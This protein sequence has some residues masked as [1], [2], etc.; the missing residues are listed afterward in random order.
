MTAKALMA[1]VFGARGTGKNAWLKQQLRVRPPRLVVWDHKHDPTMVDVGQGV[2]DLGELIR[3]MKGKRFALRYLPDH[4]GDIDAQF[5]LF[6]RACFLV[7]NLC[8][9]VDELPEVTKANRAPAAWRQ[10]V[11]VG[12]L[13]RGA[14]GVER[15]LVIFGLGQRP[16]ECDKSF[17][18]NLD[19]LHTGRVAQASDARALA[20]LLNVDYRELMRL[21]DLHWVERRQGQAEP[22][23]GVLTFKKKVAS[24]SQ[25]KKAP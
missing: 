12:R 18:N 14:D 10:C 17:M 21:E 11:N 24:G 5:D 9:V 7:G 20:D 19:V 2:T 25:Q 4:S 1:G 16:S 8:M 22:V 6:C 15:S 23:R 13:Y 3:G